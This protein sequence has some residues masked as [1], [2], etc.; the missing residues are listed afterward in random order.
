MPTH[1]VPEA[2]LASFRRRAAAL[3]LPSAP[4]LHRHLRWLPASASAPVQDYVR[5]GVWKRAPIPRTE[6]RELLPESAG[7]EDGGRLR[8]HSFLAS[9]RRRVRGR[10]A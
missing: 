1:P 10:R 6:A 9:R 5:R 4:H 8:R 3:I 7:R 2:S